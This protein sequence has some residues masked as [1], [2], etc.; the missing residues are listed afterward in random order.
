MLAVTRYPKEYVDECRARMKAQASAYRRLAASADEAAVESFTPF[1]FANLT[2]ALDASFVHRT[3]AIEGKDG[4]ALNE[5]RMLCASIL[6][7]DG[8]LT[9][10]RTIKYKPEASVL[11]LQLGD[12]IRLDEKRF[13][14]LSD[15]FFAELE[16]KFT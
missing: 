14:R 7:N 5:V 9:A 11:K 4:N 12:E 15:A 2:V 13:R 16:R 10:D 1:F 8:I 3:R 6:T